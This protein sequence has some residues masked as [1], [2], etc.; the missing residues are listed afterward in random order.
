M[1]HHQKNPT[2]ISPEVRVVP[3]DT[4]QV[5]RK[6]VARRRGVSRGAFFWGEAGEVRHGEPFE[7]WISC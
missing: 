7:P 2:Q 5:D 6:S 4:A 1:N 3:A